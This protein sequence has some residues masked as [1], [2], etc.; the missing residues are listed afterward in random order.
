MRR[1]T[2]SSFPTAI[3]QLLMKL[4]RIYFESSIVLFGWFFLE[5]KCWCINSE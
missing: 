2:G 3:K 1:S 4:I 5:A